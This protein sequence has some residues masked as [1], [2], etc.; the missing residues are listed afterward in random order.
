MIKKQLLRFIAFSV[1]ILNQ[2]VS[3]TFA[4]NATVVSYTEEVVHSEV[5]GG[6]GLDAL[7]LKSPRVTSGQ[8]AVFDSAQIDYKKRRYGQAVITDLPAT[9]CSKDCKLKVQWEHAPAGRLN[10]QV[11]VTWKLADKC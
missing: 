1:L 10:Y 7:V 2:W 8:C 11:K 4:S 3:L 5:S 6:K 9:A